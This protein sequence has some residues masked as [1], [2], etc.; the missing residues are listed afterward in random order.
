MK[1]LAIDTALAACSAAV[2]DDGQVRA[3]HFEVRERGHAEAIVPMVEQCL[4]DAGATYRDL[5]CL[6]VSTGPG[7]Y[8][9]LRIGH[10]AIRGL[11]LAADKPVVGVSC[12]EAVAHA[13]ATAVSAS[14]EGIA[15][16][17]GTKRPDV[18]FQTFRGAAAISPPDVA[19]PAAIPALLPPGP[20]LL[21][22]DAAPLVRP[23]LKRDDVRI[24][25]GSGLPDAIDI[26]A[27]AARDTARGGLPPV[28][29]FPQPLY[30]RAPDVTV[31]AGNTGLRPRL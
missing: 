20:L 23:H 21:A 11:A 8:T 22:G 29:E 31:S 2:W 13:A 10:A 27:L 1:I 19:L 17:L 26:A 12:L 28:L 6:A 7:T 14:T 5:D 9:G 25:P 24:A 30:L 4:D 3:H 18:Y 16:F 15:V